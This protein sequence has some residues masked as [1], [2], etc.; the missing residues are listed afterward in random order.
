MIN[1]IDFVPIYDHGIPMRI[2]MVL[3]QLPLSLYRDFSSLLITYNLYLVVRA[4]PDR[5]K[6]GKFSSNP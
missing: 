6:G 5:H 2:C 1:L 4:G 3:Y